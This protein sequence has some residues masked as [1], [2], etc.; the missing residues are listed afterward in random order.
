MAHGSHI[1]KKSCMPFSPRTTPSLPMAR[2]IAEMPLTLVPAAVV[3]LPWPLPV[4]VSVVAGDVHAAAR[5]LLH[6][7]EANL[8]WQVVLAR[9]RHDGFVKLAIRLRQVGAAAGLDALRA[10]RE[11]HTYTAHIV[12]AGRRIGDG[13]PRRGEGE[14]LHPAL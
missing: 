4:S 6:D 11:A 13:E 1:Q 2:A 10:A 9:R 14:A 8:R 12:R 5:L 7:S 3:N